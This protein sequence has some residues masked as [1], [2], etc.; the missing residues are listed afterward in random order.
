MSKSYIYRF[1]EDYNCCQLPAGTTIIG[2]ITNSNSYVA[3]HLHCSLQDEREVLDCR[4]YCLQPTN[5]RSMLLI[6]GLR[7]YLQWS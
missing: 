6:S 7:K 1:N 3:D 4:V 2:T 5:K